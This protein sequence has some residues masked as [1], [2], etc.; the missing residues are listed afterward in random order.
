MPRYMIPNHFYCLKTLPLTQNGKV[1][2]N[3][4]SKVDIRLPSKAPVIKP[5]TDDERN[6]LAVWHEA[7][8]KDNISVDDHFFEVGGHSLLL[9]KVHRM[10]KEA[11]YNTLTL[12]DLLR[13]PSIRMLCVF[14][15]TPHTN[16]LDRPLAEGK[17]NRNQL[18]ALRKRKTQSQRKRTD[19]GMR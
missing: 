14:L 3:K 1:D 18:N 2:K 7:L 6:I 5:S 13:F 4:L 12:V 15:N 17:S 10:L 8:G 11:G 9:N 19:I 16:K